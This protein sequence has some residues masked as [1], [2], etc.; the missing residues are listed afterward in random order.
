MS[1]AVELARRDAPLAARM[2]DER[3]ATVVDHL[4]RVPDGT[5]PPTPGEVELFATRCA[6][7]RLDPFGNQVY[8][9]FRV[10]SK[11]PLGRRMTIQTGIGGLQVVAHR[12]G[13]MDG[14]GH[15]QWCGA[16]GEWRDVWLEDGPPAAARFTVHRQGSTHPYYGV[17]TWREYCQY[18]YGKP[19][20]AWGTHGPTQLMKCAEA[21]ALRRAFPNDLGGVYAHE[22]LEHLDLD[23]PEVHE[24]A[25]E[26]KAE[27]EA[28]RHERDGRRTIT[29]A[30][31]DELGR[32]KAAAGITSAELLAIVRRIAG[33]EV[34]RLGEVE[35]R[36]LPAILAAIAEAGTPAPAQGAP[37]V[38]EAEVVPAGEAVE[39]D[40]EAVEAE[41]E[42]EAGEDAGEPAAGHGAAEAGDSGEVGAEA[43]A[44]AEA[45][46]HP[47]ADAEAEQADALPLGADA[48]D[49]AEAEAAEPYADT[50]YGPGA[51]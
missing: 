15:P 11:S 43:D 50:M 49:A 31:A 17:A 47:S 18:A 1:T 26:H 10:D 5:A 9:I 20:G 30:E 2:W 48:G 40:A 6:A 28:E 19:I 22:E 39:A 14:T 25:A 29:R 16:D 36:H 23:T 8:A 45:G 12:T 46:A 38:G 32:A 21:Q 41:H 44:E 51:P 42:P 27:R 24:A 33:A 7:M 3:L 34:E 4:M 37:T 35:R 13:L